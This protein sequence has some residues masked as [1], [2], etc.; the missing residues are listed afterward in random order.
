MKKYSAPI[1]KDRSHVNNVSNVKSHM[2]YRRMLPPG[3]DRKIIGVIILLFILSFST[4]VLHADCG[5]IPFHP[6]VKISEP[7]QRAMIA[8]NGTEEILLLSTD[9][10]ASGKTKVLR[11]IPFPSEP[12]VKIGDVEVF[13][14]AIKLI[15]QKIRDRSAQAVRKEGQENIKG[16]PAGEVTFHQFIE[17]NDIMVIHVLDVNSF[18]NWVERYFQAYE[19]QNP[20]I[21]E[22]LKAVVNDYLAEG[23]SWFV[24]DVVSLDDVPKTTKAIQYRFITE[25]LF[26]PLRI[27]R[28]EEGETSI[29]LLVLTQR[30][31]IQFPGISIEEIVLPYEPIGMSSQELR[32]LSEDME[33]VLG[34]N[35]KDI[36]LRNWHI[37]GA[38]S[39]FTKDLIVK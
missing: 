29:E 5:S 9:M 8:W 33:D 23:F 15:N 12:V 38:L 27:N 39:G 18:S 7:R 22:T 2:G 25:S 4:Q 1:N 20:Q 28:T 32:S 30:P 16:Y 26:Y 6:E 37:K 3:L 34:H 35:K 31:L 36:K 11:I 24:F 21:P 13:R 10:V 14:K 19:E 17:S